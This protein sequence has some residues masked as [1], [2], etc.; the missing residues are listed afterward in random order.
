MY[1]NNKHIRKVP[2]GRNFE[3]DS[4]NLQMDERRWYGAGCDVWGSR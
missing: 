1:T 3:G 4:C 2:R